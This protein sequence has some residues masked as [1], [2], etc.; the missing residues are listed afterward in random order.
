ML[1]NSLK[2]CGISTGNPQVETVY[3][4]LTDPVLRNYGSRCRLPPPGFAVIFARRRLQN[5]AKL[6]KMAEQGILL[7]L[8]ARDHE[9]LLK[10]T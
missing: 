1:R 3:R 6:I 9:L 2:H 7:M 4:F 5:A 10:K 8:Y